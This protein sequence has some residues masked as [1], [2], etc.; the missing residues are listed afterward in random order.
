MK[1]YSY[2]NEYEFFNPNI[3]EI[4]YLVNRA[5]GNCQD[6]CFHWFVYKCVFNIKFINATKDKEVI[7]QVTPRY[8]EYMVIES[9][10]L[11]VKN[12]TIEDN[13]FIF[14]QILKLTMIIY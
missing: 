1:E 11:D 7:F 13:G 9:D 5:D 14:S 6:K 12:K 10:E 4:N 3:H 8:G 2:L